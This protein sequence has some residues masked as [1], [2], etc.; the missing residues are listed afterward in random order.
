MLVISPCSILLV[1]DRESTNSDAVTFVH[2][3][4][5]V[6]FGE[7]D[8]DDSDENKEKNT[9]DN[10]K[11]QSDKTK[12]SKSEDEKVLLDDFDIFLGNGVNILEHNNS[13]S[14]KLYQYSK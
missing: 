12:F 9:K 8:Y 11:P 4:S 6:G 10:T 14:L 13:F 5:I 1:L 7:Y 3:D 2:K